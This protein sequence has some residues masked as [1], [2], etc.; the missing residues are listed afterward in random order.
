MNEYRIWIVAPSGP[1]SRALNAL[2]LALEDEGFAV[3]VVDVNDYLAQ[4]R[5]RARPTSADVVV[6][7]EP[8]MLMARTGIFRALAEIKRVRPATK[9]VY[10]PRQGNEAWRMV[11]LDHREIDFV[12]VGDVLLTGWRLV[13][14]LARGGD[15]AAVSGL[16]WRPSGEPALNGSAQGRWPG[17][18]WEVG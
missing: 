14:T 2:I 12:V 17:L 16:A 3:E 5:H 18:A 13:E 4:V 1:I 15:L 11:L 9:T 6:A 10:I 8:S 7:E